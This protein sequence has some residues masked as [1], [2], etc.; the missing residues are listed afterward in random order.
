MPIELERCLSL[1]G[2]DET[3]IL[4][5]ID[6]PVVAGVLPLVE[7]AELER[8]HVFSEFF[9]F[10][11]AVGTRSDG[12]D[13]GPQV[14][15]IPENPIGSTHLRA[16]EAHCGLASQD[17][18]LVEIAARET[19]ADGESVILHLVDDVM[20]EIETLPHH[21]QVV[22]ANEL[23]MMYLSLLVAEDISGH[24]KA[25]CSFGHLVDMTM[26]IPGESVQV[27]ALLVRA[28][29]PGGIPPSRVQLLNTIPVLPWTPSP[30]WTPLGPAKMRTRSKVTFP[31]D[32]T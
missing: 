7:L 18:I 22:S 10:E 2:A 27:P 13:R 31:L 1:L 21:E 23:A 25:T 16:R 4:K 9:V 26:Q 32:R 5:Q 8:R 24:Q 15:E 14:E 20:V 19:E 29:A 30:I 12:G 17:D 28:E 3:G 11:V 6:R